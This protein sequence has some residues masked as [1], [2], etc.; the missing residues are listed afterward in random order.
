MAEAEKENGV[1]I[2]CDRHNNEHP[3][4]WYIAV[5]WEDI[6][7]PRSP[8]MWVCDAAVK[9]I[10]E[11]FDKISSLQITRISTSPIPFGG[12]PRKLSET[13]A[14]DIHDSLLNRR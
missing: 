5:E 6:A 8:L 3:A 14:N 7:T 9:E 13:E 11:Q 1:G 10:L 12:W 4:D 2:T